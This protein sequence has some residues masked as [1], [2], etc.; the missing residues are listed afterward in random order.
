MF[1]VEGI[2]KFKEFTESQKTD[3]EKAQEIINGYKAKETEWSTKEVQYQSKLKASELGIA[4][5]KVEDALKLAE[6]NPENLAKVLEKYPIF[7][8]T[9]N[10]N[11]GLNQNENNNTPTG[12]TELEKYMA[13]NPAIYGQTKK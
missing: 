2:K 5:D 6:G 1:D 4:P 12:K 7:K 13:A 10:V 8:T 11:I 9:N 3:L